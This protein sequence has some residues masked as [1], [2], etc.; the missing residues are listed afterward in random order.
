MGV[1]RGFNNQA[2]SAAKANCGL[3]IRFENALD[4][5]IMFLS[6]NLVQN[7]RSKGKI[8]TIC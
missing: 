6:C 3:Q 5:G 1:M 8:P 7:Q 2:L 4:K